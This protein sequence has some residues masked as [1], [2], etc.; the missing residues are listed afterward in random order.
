MRFLQILLI[1][2]LYSFSTF[3]QDEIV[4]ESDYRRS[5]QLMDEGWVHVSANSFESSL[6]FFD[7][8]IEIYDGNTDAFVGRATALMKLE[9]LNEAERDVQSALKLSENQSDMFYLA[10]NIY[11]KMEYFEEAISYY[12]KAMK[13]NESSDVPIDSVNCY[14]NR[15]NCYFK[16]GL[17]RSAINDFTKSILMN[18][19]FF[20]AYHNRALAYKHRDDMKNACTDFRKAEE[21]GSNISEKYIKQY[22]P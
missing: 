2:I 20:N 6:A 5:K 22:C 16:A 12:T 17:Y 13:F 14:Y 18:D 11:F 21:L 8:S 9:R 4:D 3:C 10:G 19:R 7:K 15:G 1:L